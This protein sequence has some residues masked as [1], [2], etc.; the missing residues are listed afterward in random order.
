M[1]LFFIYFAQDSS[2]FQSEDMYLS[3]GMCNKTTRSC[4]TTM[5]K[6]KNKNYQLL[7]GMWGK[8]KPP[9]RTYKLL[10]FWGEIW[11]YQQNKILY[12]L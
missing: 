7:A 2:F 6:A 12:S 4:C 10:H 8:F 5:I 9:L 3:S 1:D 11:G